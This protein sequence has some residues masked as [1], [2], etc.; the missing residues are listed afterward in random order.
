MLDARVTNCHPPVRHE[1]TQ[2]YRSPMQFMSVKTGQASVRHRTQ[3]GIRLWPV[4]RDRK[5]APGF[6]SKPFQKWGREM[7]PSGVH[8]IECTN[9]LI[10]S[11]EQR[12][13]SGPKNCFKLFWKPV[14]N[15]CPERERKRVP[16]RLSDHSGRTH[17]AALVCEAVPAA[18]TRTCQIA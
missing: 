6:V 16:Q 2:F 8:Q 12:F 17:Y 18:K 1:Q 3:H 15:G 4:I 13:Q 11:P 9:G 10:L 7:D 14:Y 5:T